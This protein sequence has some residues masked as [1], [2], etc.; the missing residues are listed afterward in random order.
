MESS[1]KKSRCQRSAAAIS[2][3]VVLYFV[4][5]HCAVAAESASEYFTDAAHVDGNVTGGFGTQNMPRES[6][7]QQEI[8]IENEVFCLA[9]NIYF[10]ARSEA[11]QGQ[12]A[13]GYVVMNRVADRYYPNTVCKVVRQ[14]G[15]DRRFR[16][17]FSWWCD[18]RSDKPLDQKAWLKSLQLAISV[19]FGHSEDPTEGALWYHADYVNPYWSDALV[20]GNKIG[21][22]LFYLKKKQPK[23]A[24]N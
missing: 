21:Q 4:F 12:L 14:G 2:R 6:S 11:E 15:E 3:I 19:Y 18:G 22:H 7:A 24:L 8:R 10:E 16:C 1:T 20:L 23:Y 5:I 9:L 13:V 17:Q